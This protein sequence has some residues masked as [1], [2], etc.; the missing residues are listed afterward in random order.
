MTD[1]VHVTAMFSIFSVLLVKNGIKS[2]TPLKFLSF[3]EK[4]S[5]IIFLELHTGLKV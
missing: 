3:E 5:G 1:S 2:V 4:I